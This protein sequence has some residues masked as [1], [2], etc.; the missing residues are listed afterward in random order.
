MTEQPT[1][2]P[3]PDGNPGLPAAQN[4]AEGFRAT[5]SQGASMVESTGLYASGL[6][7]E[8]IAEIRAQQQSRDFRTIA[9]R[10]WWA[11]TYSA[12]ELKAAGLI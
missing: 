8:V 7:P 6:T 2:V 11:S 9:G 5:V 12:E 4:P 3:A 1:A 10:P